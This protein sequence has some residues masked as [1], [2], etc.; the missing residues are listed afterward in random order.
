MVYFILKCKFQFYYKTDITFLGAPQS[1][2]KTLI[3]QN[4]FYN[5]NIR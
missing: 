3:L 2:L 4:T 1:V 5:I